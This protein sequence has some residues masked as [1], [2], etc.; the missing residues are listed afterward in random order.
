[1]N[2][3]FCLGD[4]LSDFRYL[5]SQQNFVLFQAFIFGFI[6]NRGNRTLTELYQSSDSQTKYLRLYNRLDV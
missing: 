5:F 3:L 2:L 6:A 1:M 4:I